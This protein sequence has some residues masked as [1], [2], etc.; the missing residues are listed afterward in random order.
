MK[1]LLLLLL[2]LTSAA[3]CQQP[4]AP[5]QSAQPK[6]ETVYKV[7]KDVSAPQITQSPDPEYS[8][9]ARKKSVQGRCVLKLVV[10]QQGIPR[11]IK[12]IRS[13][14]YGLDEK[15]VE[16]V[17]K[18]RFKP[19]TLNGHPVSVQINVEVTFNL[20]KQ[21][22][23]NGPPATASPG[24]DII[25][26][27]GGG[28]TAPKA[29]K[30][31]DPE[32]SEEARRKHIAGNVTLMLVVEPDGTVSNIRVIQA[33]GYG[34]DE[35]AIEAVHKWRFEPGTKDGKPV[36]VQLAIGMSFHFY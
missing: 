1:T 20:Y 27:V 13:V 5:A 28:V 11:D 26:T 4:D 32:Y 33:L 25:Y 12:V 10:D 18:W 8:E 34:L 2:A 17:Q 9:E 19:A 21:A 3:F 31:V 24:P 36:R 29:I 14:G 7:G 16:A 23:E 15:A 6:Q 35:K 30:A 22:A